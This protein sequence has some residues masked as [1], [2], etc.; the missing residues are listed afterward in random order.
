MGSA[1]LISRRSLFKGLGVG[2]LLLS[3]VSRSVLADAPSTLRA[4]F[5]FHANG[6]HPGW[7]PTGSG[8]N[9]VLSPHLMPLEPIRSDVTIL[10]DMILARGSGNSHKA[11]TYSAL[12]AGGTTS[13]DQIL[14]Q[15]V[16]GTTP[17]PS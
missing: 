10:R 4:A 3:G 16:K 8:T 2:S 11:T 14:A 15:A 13:F 12:G 5:L 7:A 17:L 1:N 6:S 9:F